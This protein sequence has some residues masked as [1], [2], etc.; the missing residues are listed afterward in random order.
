MQLWLENGQQDQEGF[1]L[2][3]QALN[4]CKKYNLKAVVD[5]HILRSHHF[6]EKE[7]P[8]WTSLKRRKDSFNAGAI[9]HRHCENTR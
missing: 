9:C 8:L 7:K 6:N 1:S 3:Q 5:L 2:L 4:W